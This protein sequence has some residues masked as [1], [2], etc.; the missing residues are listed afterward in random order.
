LS[1]IENMGNCCKKKHP[2]GKVDEEDK[3]ENDPLNGGK[4]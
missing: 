3:S 1:L 2:K 4:I